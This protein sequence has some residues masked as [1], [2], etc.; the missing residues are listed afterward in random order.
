MNLVSSASSPSSVRGDKAEMK[1]SI[2]RAGAYAQSSERP[3]KGASAAKVELPS[4]DESSAVL[5]QL[6]IP[7]VDEAHRSFIENTSLERLVYWKLQTLFEKFDEDLPQNILKTVLSHVELPLFAL[8][9]KKT[10]GNQSRAAELLGCNR[11]TLHRKLKDF[12]IQPKD[13]R[14]ALKLGKFGAHADSHALPVDVPT[15]L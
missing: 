7:S 8:I 6:N 3:V 12:A 1:E 15:S 5:S 11:N 4:T 13:L 9:M 2:T 10:K 14:R